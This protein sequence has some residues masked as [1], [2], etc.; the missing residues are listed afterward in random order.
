MA[1]VTAKSLADHSEASLN[2]MLQA[3]SK[4]LLELQHTLKLG[5]L[6]NTA[7]L[8]LM[9]HKIAVIKTVLRQRSTA[10]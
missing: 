7:Q 8:K 5:K 2:E 1:F 10:S 4:E 6:S 9:R 3:A